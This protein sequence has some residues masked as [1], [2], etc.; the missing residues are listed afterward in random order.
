VPSLL[1]LCH[2]IPYPPNKGDKIRSFHWL[3][4]LSESFDIYLAAFVDDEEDWQYV[5]KLKGYCAD[6]HIVQLDPAMAKVKSLTGLIKGQP[7]TLPYYFD[8]KLQQ[9]VEHVVNEHDIKNILVFSSSMA[10]YVE[11]VKYSMCNRVIDFVDMDSDKWLQYAN[12]KSWPMSWVYQ[13]EANQLL[14]YEQ[15][16]AGAFDRSLFVSDAEMNLFQKKCAG[17]E[18]QLAYVN[19]GVDT[20]Y[21]S[22]QRH[23]DNPYDSGLFNVVFTGAMDYWANVD[24]VRWFVE[25]VFQQLKVSIP[26]LQFYIVGSKPTKQVMELQK[27]KDVFVTGAVDDIR[28]YIYHA[29]L[30]VAPMRIARGIQNKVLE[31]MAMA[32]LV[33]TSP[34][35]YEG[36]AAEIEKEII[37]ANHGHEWI[38]IIKRYD[39]SSL[40][41]SVV[42]DHARIC[43]VNKYSWQNS[44]EKLK[45][46]F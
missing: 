16:I 27:I 25:E 23:Y 33:I 42:G 29:A 20:D 46:Y 24:A 6:C 10:Q 5:E 15:M 43:V 9:W 41:N 38:D 13:R 44:V 30:A 3:K 18:R 2:R 22:P 14:K 1:Y 32:K 12:S 36:L 4:G 19:N 17:I 35:G 21:F 11:T 8:V 7:L 31:A 39:L 40:S 28:P 34:Q 37:V 26:S 45:N